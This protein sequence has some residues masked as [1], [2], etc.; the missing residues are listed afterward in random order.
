MS[1]NK[2]RRSSNVQ[3][4]MLVLPKRNKTQKGCKMAMFPRAV[5]CNAYKIQ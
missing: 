1:Q 5:E 3:H 2:E 4:E